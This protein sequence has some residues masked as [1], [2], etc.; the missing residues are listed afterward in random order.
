MSEL[1]AADDNSAG[2]ITVQLPKGAFPEGTPPSE[3]ASLI[4][5]HISYSG[6]LPPPSMFKDYENVLPGS[7]DRILALAEK[8]Q[9]L[10]RRDNSSVSRNDTVRV[11][12]SIFVS[13][14]LVL[15]ACYCAYLV[16]K[17]R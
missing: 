7:A 11:Y 9:D 17:H 2:G 13:F 16:P 15:A 3:I 10:R 5:Q 4:A 6:P 14:S 12:G 8:E 1:N